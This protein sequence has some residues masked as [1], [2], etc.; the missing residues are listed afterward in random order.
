MR[1]KSVIKIIGILIVA[2]TLLG[3]L[4][5]AA[6]PVGSIKHSP[7]DQRRTA[8][9]QQTKKTALIRQINVLDHGV[10]GIGCAHDDGPAIRTIFS[11]NIAGRTILFP[12]NRRYCFKTNVA[13][14]YP[15]FNRTGTLVSRK[16]K[17]K[18]VASGATFIVDDA[19]PLTTTF[20]FDRTTNWSWQGGS[21]V[22]NRKGLAPTSENVAIALANVQRF[23]ISDAAFTGYGGLGAA[24]AGDWIVAGE[25]T[26]L[27]MKGVG[28][29]F[30][31][32]FLKNVTVRNVVA[33]GADGKGQSGPGQMGEKCFSTIQDGQLA[34]YNRTGLAIRQTENVTVENL[35][36]S[37]FRTGVAIA[38]GQKYRF[39][40][41]NIH[42]NPGGITPGLGYYFYYING[43]NFSSVGAPVSNVKIIGG[44]IANN[45]SASNGFG[46]LVDVESITNGDK[47][48]DFTITS[49]TF[50]NRVN[51]RKRGARG[52]SIQMKSNSF[53]AN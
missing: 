42:D 20:T 11:G 27:K 19:I 50:S 6:P 46:V 12:P 14:G 31:V 35:E 15:A 53:L 25:F 47:M 21:F 48:Q 16:A 39:I 49:V 34:S 36:A 1:N 3:I 10:M 9:V 4:F 13:P 7:L 2:A 17:F 28:I 40:N 43:G 33:L 45:G 38:S 29:C 52:G 26:R 24:I 41:N 32:A 44:K 30:D 22:G 8:P 18:V 5:A 51:I 37:N 23:R